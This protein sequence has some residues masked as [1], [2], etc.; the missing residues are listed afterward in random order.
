M[1]RKTYGKAEP[2]RTVRRQSRKSEQGNTAF[3]FT[4]V[5]LLPSDSCLLPTAFPC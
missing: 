1:L 2:Y 4:A 3:L 5:C